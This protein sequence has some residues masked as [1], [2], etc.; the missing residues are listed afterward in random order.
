MVRKAINHN[1]RLLAR[2]LTV[3]IIQQVYEENIMSN[4][5]LTCELCFKPVEFGQDSIDHFTPLKRG[6][7][8]E[9]GNLGVA[10]KTCNFKKGRMTLD[11]WFD[12]HP[13]LLLKQV[14]QET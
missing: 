14:H 5:E 4:N 9:R 12:K 7:G 2:G 10:H 6:G 1:R 8:N 13:E 11:E 3:K